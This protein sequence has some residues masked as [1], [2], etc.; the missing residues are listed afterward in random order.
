MVGGGQAFRLCGSDQG[1][2]HPRT[3]L[4]TVIHSAAGESGIR[5]FSR[6]MSLES[7]RGRP[8]RRSQL[9]RLPRSPD[10]SRRR[11]IRCHAHSRT[12]HSRMP[13]ALS[14]PGRPCLSCLVT[15]YLTLLTE[16]DHL[17]PNGAGPAVGP[18]ASYLVH[19]APLPDDQILSFSLPSPYARFFR[20]P[21]CRSSHLDSIFT[22]STLPA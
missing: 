11:A 22:L 17:W 3:H 8:L 19:A 5:A 2:T 9:G 14:F 10:L 1:C 16:G 13:T 18:T 20:R 4:L 12:S 15:V 7:Q 6:G 21:N